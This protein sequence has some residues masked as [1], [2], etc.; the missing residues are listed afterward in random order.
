MSSPLPCATPVS[1]LSLPYELREQILISLLCKS[2]SIKL[3]NST[4]YKAD[5]TL[6][7]SQVCRSL[8][9][10]AIRVFYQVNTFTLTVDPEAVSTNTVL[11]S[12][13]PNVTH[14][15]VDRIR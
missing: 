6:S 15:N 9:E 1:F 5:F 8:R 12:C 14:A 13:A 7:I 4:E 11:S 10:E 3:Q 2:G